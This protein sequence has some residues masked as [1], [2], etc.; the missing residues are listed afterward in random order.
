MK[1]SKF[2]TK[3]YRGKWW[4]VGDPEVGPMGPYG[5]RADAESDRRGM[6]LFDR[7]GHLPGFVTSEIQPGKKRN[8]Q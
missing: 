3:K 2:K 4:I 7:Y 6:E 1:S 8:E 5:S